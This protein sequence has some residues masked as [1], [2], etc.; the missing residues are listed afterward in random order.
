MPASAKEG[1]T[2]DGWLELLER[3]LEDLS[4]PLV[5][6]SPSGPAL[7][8]GER[9]SVAI[10]FLDLEGFTS[11]AEKVDHE[12][13]HR[14][15]TGVMG[16]LSAVV[17]GHG[18][19]VDKFEGDRIM[20]LF[21]AERSSED[22]CSRAVSSA[23]RM[24]QVIEDLC[25]VLERY[26]LPL[27]ARAGIAFGDVTVAPDPSGHLT[28]TGDE[29]NVASRLE[30]TAGHGTIQ[31]SDRVR[32][33][34]GDLYSWRDLGEVRIRGRGRPVHIFQPTGPGKSQV[35][36]WERASALS[37][38]PFVGRKAEL[39]GLE[40]FFGAD[41]GATSRLGGARHRMAGICGDA[42]IGKSRLAFEYSRRYSSLP[43]RSLVA[44][45]T[46]LSYAQPSMWLFASLVRGLLGLESCGTPGPA[47]VAEA[48]CRLSPEGG[49]GVPVMPPEAAEALSAMLSKLPGEAGISAA[50]SQ[51]ARLA[52][53]AAVSGVLKLASGLCDRVLIILEDVHWMDSASSEVLGFISTN[54]STRRPLDFLL[55]YRPD[56]PTGRLALAGMPE[57]YVST[58]EMV[59]GEL[60]ETDSILLVSHLLGSWR[61][62]AQPLEAS[63]RAVYRAAGG[64]PF[65]LEEMALGS[66][67]SGRPAFYAGL[68]LDE[69]RPGTVE[70][71]VRAGIDGLPSDH[72]RLLQIASVIGE[73]FDSDLLE[74]VAVRAGCPSATGPVL[75]EL[76]SRGFLTRSL[77]SPQELGFRHLLTREAAYGSILRH[78]RRVLHSLCAETLAARKDGSLAGA[79]AM[80]FGEAGETRAAVEWGLPAARLAAGK[81]DNQGLF[82]WT[83][84]LECWLEG[85]PPSRS[86]TES[87]LEVL[88]LR[89][90]FCTATIARRERFGTL[91]KIRKLM[92]EEGL[93]DYRPTYLLSLAAY[94][95]D[96]EKHREAVETCVEA[97][98]IFQARGDTAGASA[99]LARCG[100]SYRS[101]G[102]LGKASECY[103]R[104][105][106]LLGEEGSPSHRLIALSGLGTV[107]Q[108]QGRLDE[109]L[110]MMSQALRIA[111]LVGRRSSEANILAGMG[112]VFRMRRDFGRA[113]EHIRASL[114]LS[115]DMG[116]RRAELSALNSMC[117]LYRD[118]EKFD[119]ALEFG[120]RALAAS[121]ELEDRRAEGNVLCS[122]GILERRR[123][124]LSEAHG[125]YVQSLQAHRE[126]GN[127][128][129][130]AVV[131]GNL[132][133]LY[134]DMWR[135]REAM[136]SYR[137]AAE[138]QRQ[139]GNRWALSNVTGS[140]ALRLM[141]EDRYE[142][143]APVVEEC[144]AAARETGNGSAL[145]LS[146]LLRAKAAGR[147]GD[148]ARALE[149][150][151]GAL[152]EAESSGYDEI[153]IP[154]LIQMGFSEHFLGRSGE[155][156]AR[157]REA[158]EVSTDD[159]S[160]RSFASS[161]VALAELH[162][163]RGELR[164]A[165]QAAFEAETWASGSGDLSS[166]AKAREIIAR[167]RERRGRPR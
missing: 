46:C 94:F 66:A 35:D 134:S 100:V 87:M 162:L 37:G 51:E 13:L 123:G 85:E 2:G 5:P 163:L 164:E 99:A 62:G 7:I 154:C 81:H 45:A 104:S 117:T 30:E 118:M 128:A 72:R 59:L 89:E 153:V 8:P 126:I 149:L 90:G 70:G 166:E 82:D 17:E 93:D 102:D 113:L 167:A 140:L 69:V 108:N 96:I 139:V 36:R 78:N 165:E 109:A 157:V 64:N 86:R 11:L 42:G 52:S 6:H 58:T 138:L 135:T 75:D 47:E 26:D 144:E 38:A 68:P 73:S 120:D 105:L 131:L 133:N 106:A 55:T 151:A 84:K 152:A 14:I 124:R 141:D 101:M 22:D 15:V 136:E 67:G 112:I 79:I 137:Q 77:H 20:A 103:E 142:E 32:K 34:C 12:V 130:E 71:I 63:A 16:A 115:V 129:G 114:D 53:L 23:V 98:G 27:G 145:A 10:L 43:G 160:G 121:R 56:P 132:G 50:E 1:H 21:G 25:H 161:S 19:Y 156:L 80:H 41:T 39:S 125:R 148:H 150:A 92:D 76:E 61:A 95:G 111:R 4:K 143:A 158:V 49:G 60:G 31:V 29:V 48:I 40:E 155:G 110:D 147:A 127:R 74:A 54:C 24:M 44:R 88:Q 9:R 119:E 116:L 33:E 122:L 57:G 159:G 83:V 18:G 91:Q 28:A 3:D 146:G 97:L 107:R 65:L